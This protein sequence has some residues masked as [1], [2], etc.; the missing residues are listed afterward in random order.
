MRWASFQDWMDDAIQKAGG[1]TQLAEKVRAL[2]PKGQKPITVPAIQ[3]LARRGAP[4]GKK[5]AQGSRIAHL[6]ARATGLPMYG[7]DNPSFVRETGAPYS[8]KLQVEVP[9]EID[10]VEYTRESLQIARWFKELS[11]AT[12]QRLAAEIERAYHAEGPVKRDQDLEHLARPDG[13]IA[14]KKATTKKGT[15]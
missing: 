10:G 1:R 4:K 5:P 2:Q 7:D 6:I 8:S 11:G 12:R 15:Q 9:E 14:A 3:Y 13:E